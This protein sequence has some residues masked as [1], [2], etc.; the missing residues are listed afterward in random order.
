MQT[1]T[2]HVKSAMDRDAVRILESRLYKPPHFNNFWFDVVRASPL[3]PAVHVKHV[4]V[5]QP[6]G[7]LGW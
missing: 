4:N 5:V 2:E 1:Q 3:H 6:L 7:Y